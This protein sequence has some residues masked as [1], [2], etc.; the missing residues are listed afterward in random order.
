MNEV[1]INKLLQLMPLWALLIMVAMHF[2]YRFY[3]GRF[4]KL[5][6]R[7]EGLSKLQ[8]EK[9]PERM[10]EQEYKTEGLNEKV[11]I[12]SK[13]IVKQDPEIAIDIM[14]KRSPYTLTS[15]GEELLR[16]SYAREVLEQCMPQYIS[17]LEA[18]NPKTAYD[19]E[20]LA[21]DV[22]F[23]H[24]SDISFKPIKDFIYLAPDPMVFYSKEKGENIDVRISL[25]SI[26][27]AMALPLRDEYLRRHP[28]LSPEG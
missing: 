7:V 16:V 9:L 2:G 24:S 21:Y 19:V 10:K 12:L 25:L 23:R 1:L 17:A 27:K 15:V 18:L 22:I 3:Y 4:S 11:T 28:E 5:E 6:E 14:Q 20:D 8:D 26:I 13:W